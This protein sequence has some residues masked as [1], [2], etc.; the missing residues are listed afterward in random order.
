LINGE[1]W[2]RNKNRHLRIDIELSTV[3]VGV[4]GTELNLV[5]NGEDLSVVTVLRGTVMAA[6]ATGAIPVT[7]GQQ[8]TAVAGQPLK[9]VMLLT[10]TD[11]I[12][13]T[14]TIPDSLFYPAFNL[15]DLSPENAAG[16]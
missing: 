16:M 13:W 4:R 10:P 5:T 8:V 14:L 2:L 7:A 11:A 1:I 3:V 15:S 12:Q 6:N 9:A